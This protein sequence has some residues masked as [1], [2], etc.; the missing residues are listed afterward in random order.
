MRICLIHGMQEYTC[1]HKG[2]YTYWSC[3]ECHNQP[4]RKF[5]CSPEVRA[6]RSARM[7]G[8]KHLLGY[9]HTPA[10]LAKMSA[11]LKGV[12]RDK[13][14]EKASQWKGGLSFEPYCPKFNPDLKRRIRAFFDHR[15]VLCGK[16]VEENGKRKQLMACHHVEYN[17]Q[18]CCDGQPVHF[19]A[20]CVTCHSIT[21][22]NR[23]RWEAMLHRIIDEIYGG[24]SYFTKDEWGN[25]IE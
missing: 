17:K 20:L 3:L 6:D 22:K 9:K 4:R 7:M 12:N 1:S 14:G 18:A 21:G 10:S 16:G 5:G 25:R 24:K 11:S 15:C 23:S 8:N 2:K 19:A 13:V